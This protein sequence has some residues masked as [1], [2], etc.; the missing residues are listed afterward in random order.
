MIL[1]G[2]P[3]KPVISE[4]N[5]TLSSVGIRS[6]DVLILRRDAS[7]KSEAQMSNKE[8]D[9]RGVL[10]KKEVPS[11]NSCLFA[12]VH[13][14]TMAGETE[15]NGPKSLR[16]LVANHIERHPDEYT[17]AMLGRTNSEYSDWIKRDT[18]WG[19][20]IEL[21]ILSQHFQIEI[22]AVQ[23]STCIVNRF[24]EDKAYGT[25]IFLLY[26]GIH[27]DPLYLIHPSGEHVHIFPTSEDWIIDAARSVAAEACKAGQFTDTGSF[28]LKCNQCGFNM[29]GD[30]AAL[31]H[32]QD[33]SHTD[34]AEIKA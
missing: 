29:K 13:F 11:D 15:P 28:T 22:A 5:A 30:H 24:G 21:A 23:I 9:P 32:A 6:G 25:R 27:Y 17:D 8:E 12:S 34:F 19:G 26:D 33:T 10:L 20:S 18:S 14:L 31:Q 1:N 2:F 7:K 4:P 3:P 16:V